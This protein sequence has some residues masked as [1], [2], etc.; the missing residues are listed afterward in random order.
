[1]K[2]LN[3]DLTFEENIDLKHSK[4]FEN[5]KESEQIVELVRS[6]D[7]IKMAINGNV[8]IINKIKEH[9]TEEV[10]I[11]YLQN[12][13]LGLLRFFIIS[14]ENAYKGTEL[15]QNKNGTREERLLK[16]IKSDQEKQDIFK[17]E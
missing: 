1:M 13:Y 17:K 3:F 6:M 2:Y 4:R 16:W 11:K 8:D 7:L 14:H 9:S 5:I 12:L 10:N 15:D